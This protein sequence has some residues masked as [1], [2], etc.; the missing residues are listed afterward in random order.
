MRD[1]GGEGSWR[2]FINEDQTENKREVV[3]RI[4]IGVPK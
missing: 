3:D 4:H 1:P 2:C